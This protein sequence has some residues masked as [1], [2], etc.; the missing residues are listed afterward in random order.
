[1]RWDAIAFEDRGE[2]FTVRTNMCSDVIKIPNLR[3]WQV[4]ESIGLPLG[5]GTYS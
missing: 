4:S 2:A 3:R 5:D 1:M